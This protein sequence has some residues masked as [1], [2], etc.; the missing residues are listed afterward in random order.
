METALFFLVGALIGLVFVWSIL[1]RYLYQ[2]PII[3][4]KREAFPKGTPALESGV[5][6]QAYIDS[7]RWDG[8][9][10]CASCGSTLTR[11]PTQSDWYAMPRYD[12]KTGR[13]L[14]EVERFGPTGLMVCAKDMEMSRLSAFHRSPQSYFKNMDKP[15]HAL[16][17]VDQPP[18]AA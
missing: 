16:Y 7:I 5:A 2:Q 13:T 14:T 17:Y 3:P 6:R 18:L 1:R 12:P 4:S 15:D 10:Y 9:I 8:E 11:I